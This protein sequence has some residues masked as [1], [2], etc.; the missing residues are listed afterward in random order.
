MRGRAKLGW[1]VLAGAIALFILY[2]KVLGLAYYWVSMK[3]G[4]DEWE[5]KGLWLPSYHA[6]VDGLPIQGLTRNA[7]GL[8]FNAETGTLFSVINRPPQIA[9]LTTEGQLLRLIPISGASDPEGITHVRGDMYVI[10]DERDHQLHWV[11]I[12][13]E[14]DLVTVPGGA[15]LGLGIDVIWNLGL[16]GVS[17]DHVKGRLFIVKEKL[18]LRIL[19]ISGLQQLLDGGVFDLQIS[20]WK[21]SHAASLFMSDLSSLTLHEPSGNMLM[22][23]DE[24]ALIVEYAPNGD[25]VSMMPL[26]R[27][28]HGLS[29]TVP[30]AE[31]IAIGPDGDI[32][33]L[34]EPNL[35]YRFKRDS[36]ASWSASV[37]NQPQR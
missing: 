32:Y 17:W 10:A 14:T 6:A 34:S 1:L 31:G 19:V 16:E 7:S 4:A 20:E 26:W 27:G 23:S 3:A 28:M 35:F 25:P 33:L 9:E 13:A 22:L 30:Q 24:S 18:P 8:T 5:E 36:P 29:R 21:S 37:G 2:F 11:R 15:R 12:G